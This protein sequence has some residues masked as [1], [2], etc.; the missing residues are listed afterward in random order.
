MGGS[1]I[2]GWF[3]V[4]NPIKMDGLGIGIIGPMS[5]CSVDVFVMCVALQ[6]AQVWHLSVW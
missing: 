6:A 3:I 5:V 1:P 4:E 2:A